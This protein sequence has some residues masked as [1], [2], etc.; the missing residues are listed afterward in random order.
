MSLAPL[1]VYVHVPF[2][3]ARCGYCDFNVYGG[4][5][6]LEPAYL[7]ALLG[8]VAAW[9]GLLER[10]RVISVYFGGGTPGE[11]PPYDLLSILSA[12]RELAGEW[13]EGAEVTVEANPGTISDRALACLAA[14]GVTR[15]SF[16]VQSFEA[17]ELRFLDR[18]HSPEAAAAAVHAAR[19]A[20]ARSVS[21]DLLYG[22]PGQTYASWRRSLERAVSLPVDHIS[23]YALTVE[24]GTRLARK[25]ARGEVRM[26]PDEFVAA[27]YEEATELLAGHGL[28][29]YELSN[30]ARPGHESRH[31]LVY[32]TDGEYLGL[33]C[34]AHGYVEGMRYENV[35][36]PKEYIRALAL[37]RE[38]PPPP[39]TVAGV[40]TM[41]AV[42]CWYG[43]DPALEMAEWVSLRLRL[44]EGFATE[45][46]RKRFGVSLEDLA[47][48]EL[49]EE[50][51]AGVIEV[52][53]GRMKLTRQGRLLHG[54][55]A[56]RLLAALRSALAG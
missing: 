30:W 47:E 21:L 35:A 56:A 49:E 27:Q 19:C 29:Q 12:L 52:N 38:G 13:E 10:R 48:P 3:F 17:E 54:E 9:R 6:A 34:G 4:R 42:A 25:V 51:R 26:P 32:W 43:A 37:G 31:N 20:G 33:G 11:V 36:H 44:L 16:G 15:F 24:E 8:E 39:R 46:F 22:V 41:P 40:A 2:C 18:M 28:L 53:G 23:C 45:E 1:A 50:V 7:D 5:H 14:G 55:V